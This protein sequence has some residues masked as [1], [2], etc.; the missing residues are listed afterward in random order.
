MSRLKTG[1]MAAILIVA[2]LAAMIPL[3]RQPMAGDGRIRCPSVILSLVG[4][5]AAQPLTCSLWGRVVT[6]CITMAALGAP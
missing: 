4:F 5:G 6:S 1:F 3:L 2:M